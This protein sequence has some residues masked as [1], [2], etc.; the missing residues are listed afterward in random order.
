MI[1]VVDCADG[2]GADG[3]GSAT[4]TVRGISGSA[5]D[6]IEMYRIE[7]TICHNEKT[8]KNC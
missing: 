6:M 1:A 2:G 8:K 3:T 7:G 4:A 5:E